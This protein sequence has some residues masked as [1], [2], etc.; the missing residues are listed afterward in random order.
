MHT[1]EK[2]RSQIVGSVRIRSQIARE[3]FGP[4]PTKKMRARNC[5]STTISRFCTRMSRRKPD[6]KAEKGTGCRTTITIFFA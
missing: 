1:V 3:P 6:A 4:G 2:E 5:V